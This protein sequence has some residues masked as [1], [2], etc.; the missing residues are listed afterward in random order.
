MLIIHSRE[1][2][3]KKGGSKKNELY[4]FFFHLHIKRNT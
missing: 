4:D 2:T 3:V 1:F